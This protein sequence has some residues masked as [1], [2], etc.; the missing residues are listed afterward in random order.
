[1]RHLVLILT[2]S[3]LML[4]GVAQ[5]A[6]AAPPAVPMH[7]IPLPSFE[8]P[9][10]VGQPIRHPVAA[11]PVPPVN[12]GE[13]GWLERLWT[14]PIATFNMALALFALALATFS[15]FQLRPLR[16]TAFAARESAAALSALERAYVFLTVE[17]TNIDPLLLEA[18][19]NIGAEMAPM[20]VDG[21]SVDYRYENHGN[22]PA[23]IRAASVEFA[24]LTLLPSDLRY[25]DTPVDDEIVIRG[26]EANPR[27]KVETRYLTT[28]LTQ[29]DV[30]RL[31]N[32]ES[33][34]W[35]Y[36]HIVYDD[37]FG[38]GHETAFCWYYDGPAKSFYQY[39]G[40]RYNYR[41]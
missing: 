11:A 24:H 14:D 16:H 10:I 20:T 29:E 35:F 33:F 9:K 19:A 1:M 37:I 36:G 3:I 13:A 26:G 30:I 22:T 39:G 12:L 32:G 25:R 23:V 38:K 4:A 7:E 15:Y 40:R 6:G 31:S 8:P 17:G 27:D 18:R 34:L 21:F 41:T 28:P 5:A 2:A